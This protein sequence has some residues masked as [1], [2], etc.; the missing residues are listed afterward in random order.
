[1]HKALKRRHERCNRS[2]L[3]RLPLATAIYLAVSSMAFA[4]EVVQD[5]AAPEATNESADQRAAT[6]DTVTVTA[7]K[8]TENLQKVPISIQVL[9]E[10]K[11]QELNITDFDDY[12]KFAPSVSYQ[13]LGPGFAQVYMRGVASGGDGNHSTSLP[14]VGMY[15]DEQPITTI[16][17]ALDLHLYDINR[18][19][20]LAGPQGT[21]YGASSQAGTIRIITNK[22]DPSGFSAG[23]ALEANTI[24][25]G[26]NG[27]VA[28]GFVNVPLAENAAIRLVGWREKE[29][30]FIDNVEGDRQFPSWGG[31]VSNRD[32]TSTELLVCTERAEDDYNDIETTGARLALKVDFNENWSVTPSVM[33]QKQTTNGLFAFDP[34]LGDLKVKH[35]Y[36]ER[37][38]DSWMQAALTVE[39]KIGNFDVTYAFA[40]L[41][42]DDEVDSDYSDYSFW[43]DTIAGYGAS[44]YND[45]GELINPSQYI[46]GKDKYE[47]TSHEL[48]ITSPEDWRLRFVGGVFWQEQEHDIQQDYRIDGFRDSDA[49]PGWPDSVWLTKQFRVDRDQAVFGEVSYDITDQLTVNAGMRFFKVD[50][51]LKGFHGFTGYIVDDPDDATDAFCADPATPYKN[52]PC[53][54]IDKRIRENDHIGKLNLTYEL[55]DTKLIYA[56]WSEGYR[57]GGNNRRGS[58]PPYV[59]DYLTNYEFGWKTTWFDNRLAFNGSVFRQEWEDF[60]FSILGANGLTEVKNANQAQIDGVEMELNWAATYN[61]RLSGGAAFYDAKLTENFCGWTDEAGNSVTDC[62]PGTLNPNGTFD[63]PSDDTAVEGPEAPDGTRLPVTPK[64]KGNLTARYTFDIGSLETYVQGAYVHVGE[65]T[66]DLRL[67]ERGILGDLAAYDVFDFAVGVRKDNWALDFFLSNAFDERAEISRFAQCAETVCGAA[68]VVPEY[69]NGQIYTVTNQPRTFGIRFSQNF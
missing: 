52:A 24:S 18:V 16:Q 21:L 40:N 65:R 1:M 44:I 19:E 50:N 30:G 9:G 60:Q 66:S 41:N 28:E 69:P 15:L 35:F 3:S 46:Q 61:L 14:S 22:P 20:V 8:R 59:S 17:G 63:D 29:A 6:L 31:S 5:P 56:T 43:Y 34:A 13:S 11:L 53:V 67:L 64:F 37:S 57:P 49:V 55:S 58:L 33:G 27:Y 54:N 7:Q 48:R 36:P 4:Q 51:S 32:C 62:P 68:G 26:G 47:K 23:Y 39:G 25:D 38:E 10:Q 12:A 2:A 45:A 42:R